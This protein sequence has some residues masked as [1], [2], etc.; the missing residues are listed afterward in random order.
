M[1]CDRSFLSGRD[2]AL[3]GQILLM[4]FP[5][6]NQEPFKTPESIHLF[7]LFFHIDMTPRQAFRCRSV[8]PAF[9][10]IMGVLFF[11]GGPCYFLTAFSS[12]IIDQTIILVQVGLGIHIQY[13]QIYTFVFLL[14]QPTKSPRRFS[15]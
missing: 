1:V 8:L 13:I 9:Q 2:E 12:S 7:Y 6:Q 14:R 3:G 11:N 15:F 10:T 4:Y 5:A